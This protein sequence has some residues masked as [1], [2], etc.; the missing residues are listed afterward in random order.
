MADTPTRAAPATAR[1]QEQPGQVPDV[2]LVRKAQAGDA[3]AFA[4][5]VGRHQR[6]LYRLALRMTGSE[7]DAQ[8]VLQGGFFKAF[9]K[10]AN[11][12]GEGPVSSVLYRLA[13]DSGPRRLRR[14]HR[15]RLALREKLGEYFGE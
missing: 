3:A 11:F 8:G 4:E 6:Q 13:A 10:L 15:A 12:P 5:L 14:L 7:A 2:E 9:Q 1:E